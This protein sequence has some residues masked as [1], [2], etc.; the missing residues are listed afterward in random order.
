MSI[1]RTAQRLAL[2]SEASAAFEKGQEPR[3]ARIGADRTAQL[4]PRVGGR[5]DRPGRASTPPPT[6]RRPRGSRSGPARVNRLLGTALDRRRAARRCSPAWASRPS[7]PRPGTQVVVALK[8]EPLAVDGGPDEALTARRARPGAAT[9]RSRRTSPR[10]SPAS[11]ATSSCPRSRR[12]RDA[13]SSAPS[14]LEVAGAGPRHARRRRPHRGRDDRARVARAT[15]RRSCWPARSR[16]SAT[17]DAAG[18]RPDRRRQPAVARPLG[19]APEPAGQPAR[20][21]GRQ[22]PPRDGRRRGVRDRQG[23]RPD[24][25]RAARVVAARVRARRRRR[26]ARPG[27]A[28]P[29]P[30]DLDDAKGVLELL[31]HAARPRRA[32]ACAPEAG[33]AVFH[34]GRTAARA[35]PATG[36]TR[37]VGEVHPHIAEAWELRTA[38]RVIVAEVALD[39]LAAGRL[40]PERAPRSAR[41]PE[42]DRDL[43]IVVPE[44]TPA[45]AVEA[46]IRDHAGELLRGVA[47]VR[48]LPRRAPRREREEP[49][50]PAA[51]RCRGSDAHRGRGRGR[52]G[53]RRGGAARRRGPPP[54]LTPAIGPLPDGGRAPEPR[55]GLSVP[56]R[57]PSAAATLRRGHAAG[58]GP[59]AVTRGIGVDIVETS[60]SIN[61][62]R[63][64][65]RPVP[66]R[67]VRPGLRPGR[68]S[69]A[70]I[71]HRCRSSFSFFLAAAAVACRFGRLP[72]PN[73]TQVPR[74]VL[75]DDRVPGRLRRGGHRVRSSSIQGTYTKTELFAKYPVVDE[76]LGGILGVVQGLLFL[77]FLTIILDQYFL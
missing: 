50:L 21:R 58:R 4:H 38:D 74:R 44:A 64:A 32:V 28:P 22:P 6:C 63:P 41:F 40:A 19:A 13:R 2:R 67:D 8:P 52:G 72:E 23:L 73:W 7:R 11:A 55:A 30:Y 49:G 59:A 24:R 29:R 51:A 66:V 45:A 53:G 12:T 1:R 3:L 16:P 65:G 56:L 33:E 36:S 26:A 15:S 57:R 42:V 46:V 14:P 20:R 39:G 27:T 17:S 48:H 5:R 25:R 35:T 68:R 61:V 71:G 75:G 37:M 10:R 69:A 70:S 34:P 62:V 18:R 54:H 31:A 77:L 47:P 43:A 9:S 76:I 60:S